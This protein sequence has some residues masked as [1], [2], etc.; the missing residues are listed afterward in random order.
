MKSKRE[1]LIDVL[2]KYNSEL[3]IF[4][5]Y[6]N[7]FG[8]FKIVIKSGE[9]IHTFIT[10]RGEIYHNNTL[11]CD[12]SYHKAGIDDT[13]MKLVEVIKQKLS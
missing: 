2:E 11:I 4:E 9:Q 8:N 13:F 7:I 5:Y 3:I 10:D 1:I 12:N 6:K